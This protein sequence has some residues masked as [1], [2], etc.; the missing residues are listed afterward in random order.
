[1]LFLWEFPS[2]IKKLIN[3]IKRKKSR[4]K[5]ALGIR[6]FSSFYKWPKKIQIIKD[7]VRY[8]LNE[9]FKNYQAIKKTVYN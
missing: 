4:K 7:L 8:F 9:D 5:L 2:G 1:M 3:F 6:K